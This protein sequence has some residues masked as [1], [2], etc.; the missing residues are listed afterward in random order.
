MRVISQSGNFD[1][2]YEN[3]VL[4]RMDDSNSILCIREQA[5]HMKLQDILQRKKLKRR[6]ICAG[7][8]FLTT[9]CCVHLTA[10]SSITAS[11]LLNLKMR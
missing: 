2:P 4:E 1:F 9:L 11:Q 7:K 10:V 3:I 8:I 6:W 5:H